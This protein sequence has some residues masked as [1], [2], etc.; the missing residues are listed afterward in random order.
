MKKQSLLTQLGDVDIR[1]LRVFRTVTEA[2][3]ISAAELELNIGRSVISRHLKDLETRLGLTLCRRGRGGFA[4]TDEGQQIY[5]A[6]LRLLAS[7]ESFRNEVNELHHQMT[8]KLSIAIFD[9]TMTNPECR[10][11][12]AVKLFDTKAPGVSLEMHVLTI[13]DIEKGVMDGQFGIGIIPEHRQSSRLT[14]LGLFREKMYLY[15]GRGHPLFEVKADTERSLRHHKFAGLGYHSPNMEVG[16]K[17][18]IKRDATCY[19]QEAVAALVLSGCYI[20]YL[21]DHYARSFE[22]QSQLKRVDPNRYTY[23]CSFVAIYQHSPKPSRIEQTFLECLE[24]AHRPSQKM[25]AR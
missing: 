16:L 3:G 24:T 22:E 4:L 23:E 6:S 1:L 20:G 25:P 14:Y 10:I 18:G 17:E 13:N 12:E 19:D 9:K 5:N 15:V 11:P 2:G 7:I 8:G 21:P